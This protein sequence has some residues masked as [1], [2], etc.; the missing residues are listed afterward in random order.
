MAVRRNRRG[1][2]RLTCELRRITCNFSTGSASNH[3]LEEDMAKRKT[4]K[5]SS[6]AKSS[7]KS[8]G[9]KSQPV[10]SNINRSRT[11][12]KGKTSSTRS[13]FMRGA[14]T[15][16]GLGNW[17]LIGLLGVLV[18][19]AVLYFSGALNSDS[20]VVTQTGFPTEISVDEA[21]ARY[22][23]GAF[24][25]DVREVVEWNTGHVP[26]TTNIPL[27]QLASRISELPTDQDIVVICRSG[28]RSMEGR[29]I[30][31]DAGFKN[32][33]SVAGGVSE[34]KDAGYPYEGEILR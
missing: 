21:H 22:P 14:R 33:T 8:V 16:G 28:N 12:S 5:H 29:D 3:V 20:S 18:V 7:S 32:V 19:F 23:E 15:R 6:K 4:T 10:S 17:G 25:L 30:L 1:L 27:S 24:F 2:P 9:A 11:M 26:G 13:A 34:W 31:L